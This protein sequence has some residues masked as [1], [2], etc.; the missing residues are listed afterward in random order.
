MFWPFKKK[1]APSRPAPR[2]HRNWNE[3]WKIGDTA[4]CVREN[5]HESVRPW[6]RLAL[7]TRLTVTGF[8]EGV[9]SAGSLCY[10]LHFKEFKHGFS[11]NAFRKVRPVAT[12][13]SEIV[14]RILNAPA[15][16][17]KVREPT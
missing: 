2:D 6:E 12:E 5:W 15:G 1:Q 4:E 7:G 10:F 13:K 8:S 9:G 16:R 3:D 17:D 11:T 14:E